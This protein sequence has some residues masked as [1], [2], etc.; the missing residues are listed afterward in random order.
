MMDYFWEV[1]SHLK[2]NK[3]GGQSKLYK[4]HRGKVIIVNGM[5]YWKRK[6][7]IDKYQPHQKLE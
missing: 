2:I 3:G 1:T 5:N 7:L 4:I 6:S